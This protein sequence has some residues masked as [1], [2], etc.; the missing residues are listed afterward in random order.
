MHPKFNSQCLILDYP[1]FPSW[2]GRKGQ[3]GMGLPH[4]VLQ[5][6]ASGQ[7][8]SS[9]PTGETKTREKAELWAEG[10]AQV[11]QAEKQL[12]NP[13][14]TPKRPWLAS[15]EFNGKLR[16]NS[17]GRGQG[18]CE[19]QALSSTCLLE[20]GSFTPEALDLFDNGVDSICD[21]PGINR[22]TNLWLRKG[23]HEHNYLFCYWASQLLKRW[24]LCGGKTAGPWKQKAELGILTPASSL[25][26]LGEVNI[27]S[28]RL[29]DLRYKWE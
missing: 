27:R 20:A 23:L 8:L 17:S 28:S 6:W 7:W 29:N 1:C 16:S 11:H 18:H 25:C 13:L 5:G 12:P 15:Q 4:H 21:F 10:T 2:Q 24:L 19:G 9:L 22:E 3:E 14:P 26:D